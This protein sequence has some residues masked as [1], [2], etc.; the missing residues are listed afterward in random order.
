MLALHN[1]ARTQAGLPPLKI[2]LQL[3]Q[4]AQAHAAW[5]S[6]KPVQELWSLGNAG[7]NGEAGSG[8]VQ[9]IIAAGYPAPP[10]NVNENYGTFSNATEAFDWWMNDPVGAPGHRP[11]ILSPL[12]T[13]I[14]IGVVKH[15]SG[16]S[17]VFIINFG[18][19]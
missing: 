6:Q 16:L 3:Q 1:A 18:A 11:Q 5:L 7:H 8:Y 9:R 17:T 19:R 2:D 15:S 4:A 12:Y 14:G 10:Q 13:D